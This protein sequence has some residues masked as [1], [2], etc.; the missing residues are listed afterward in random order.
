MQPSPFEVLRATPGAGATTLRGEDE[1][2]GTPLV[3]LHGL[4]A[5]RRN[6]LQGSRLLM[7][8]GHRLVSYDA[9][10]HG[11]SSAAPSYGYP[12][13]LDDLEAVL[14][15]RGLERAALAGS[16]M[17]AAT[18]MAF[19]L[20]RPDRVPALVQITPAHRGELPEPEPW[21]RLAR[22]LER[23]G[24][25]AFVDASVPEGLPGRWREPV[26]RAVRQR[27]ERHADLGAVALALRGVPRSLAWRGMGALE[28]V[29]VPTLVIGSRDEADPG[30][31]LAVAEEYGRRL[32]KG[33]L[34]IE[35][36][37]EAPLA[38]RGGRLSE[39]I[40]EFLADVAV[41]HREN[42]S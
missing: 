34:V 15:A 13:L 31:P 1:G 4:T 29:E 25:E 20:E 28:R 5:T 7:R 3:L 21:D 6:V 19:A 37:G 24:V 17:G 11:L 23:G 39:A 32:P 22:A 27:M 8:R 16:S 12:E 40:A 30:H 2:G 10:G 9:R 35:P 42:S 38:W 26:R 33:R 41:D 36:P 14:D 18:A